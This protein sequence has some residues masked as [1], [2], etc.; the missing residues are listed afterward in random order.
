[1]NE[2]GQPLDVGE[3]LRGLDE[4]WANAKQ[5]A[6]IP[7]GRFDIPVQ[8]VFVIVGGLGSLWMLSRLIPT[9]SKK[10]QWDPVT[11]TL[12][13]PTGEK[14]TPGDIAEFDKRDWKKF[15]IHLLVKPDHPTLG[16]KGLKIDLYTHDKLESWILEMERL[17]YPERAAGSAGQEPSA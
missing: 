14:L 16:G 15:F 12:T 13:L 1:M 17:A 6:P 10:Y 8:W 2:Q 11:K 7:L 9:I 5:A 3:L 4:R